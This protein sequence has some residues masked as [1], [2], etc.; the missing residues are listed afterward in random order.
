MS[1]IIKLLP[2]AIANQIAAGEVVQRPASVVKEL[3]ENAI[4]ANSSYVCVVVKDAGKTLIQVTDNG[5]GMSHTDA[6]MCFERHATSKIQS[7]ED[8]FRI[9]TLGFRGEALA[10]I[11]AVAQVGLT[12]RQH[13]DETG[14]QIIV[15]GSAFKS[16]EPV[17][18]E[19]GTSISVKNLFYN[20][21]AR[22]NFLKSHAVEMHHITEEFT[23]IALAHPDITFELYQNDT[24]MY[25]LP[26]GKL[27]SRIADLFGKDTQQQILSCHEE[28]PHVQ[29]RGYIGQPDYVR[30]TR[31][32]QYFF[33]N[34]RF[35]KNSYLNHAVMS[36]YEAMLPED[37]FPFYVLF[38]DIDPKHIDVN[39][40]P[41]KTEIKLE[42]ERTVYA[43]VRAAVKRSLGT[44]LVIPVT[45]EDDNQSFAVFSAAN[46]IRD[47]SA[48]ATQT[49]PSQSNRDYSQFKSGSAMKSSNLRNWESLYE[50]NGQHPGDQRPEDQKS[51]FDFDE[52]GQTDEAENAVTFQSAANRMPT[53]GTLFKENAHGNSESPFQ[54]HYTYIATQVKSGLMIIDQQAAHERILFEQYSLSLERRSGT[55]QQSLFPQTLHLNP[56][57][58]TLLQELKDEIQALG[59][60]LVLTGRQAVVINGIPADIKGGNETEILE[61]LIE[62]YK[63]NQSKLSLSRRDNLAR[64]IA[65]RMAVKKGQKL[66]PAEMSTLIDR[67]FACINSNYSPDGQQTFY[68]L[69][70]NNIAD[71]FRQ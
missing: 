17:A 7:A 50:Q 38:I 56:A 22:R 2:D 49:Q 71:F 62:Q 55:S 45:E 13:Q 34:Q 43:I 59:F 42:D 4:D 16:S 48:P 44:N 57:D 68:I 8:I 46:N 18:T 51:Y 31:G 29:I 63:Y 53:T 41:T 20:I 24:Q 54:I 25:Y 40:H 52:K 12:T 60:D 66:N 11:A 9:K 3:V 6:R 37:S 69:E 33:I 5:K 23:R 21:P 61:G 1:D 14:T 58:F 28:T 67:L 10:S 15:E 32:H 36:A 19:P 30:K 27:A 47:T 39:V 65:K 70:L 64:S 26:P 35:I